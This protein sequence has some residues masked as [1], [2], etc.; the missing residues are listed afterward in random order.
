MRHWGMLILFSVDGIDIRMSMLDRLLEF[1]EFTGKKLSFG[2]LEVSLFLLEMLNQYRN[3]SW[4]RIHLKY[5]Q[6]ASRINGAVDG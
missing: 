3:I 1:L 6:T 4:I 5:Y 2:L